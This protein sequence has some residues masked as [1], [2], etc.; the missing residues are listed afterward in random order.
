MRKKT[1]LTSGEDEMKIVWVLLKLGEIFEFASF[2]NVVKFSSA[3][4]IKCTKRRFKTRV[5]EYSVM[6]VMPDRH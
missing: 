5:Y 4:R 2:G 3:A 1:F 6:Q